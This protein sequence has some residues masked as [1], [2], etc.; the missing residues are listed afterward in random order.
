MIR[1]LLLAIACATVASAQEIAMQPFVI[2]HVNRSNSP[3]DVSFLLDAPA[4]RDGFVRIKDGHLIKPNGERLRLWGVNLTG[5][6]RGPHNLP[7]K[8]M[9][10]QWPD[11]LARFGITCVR[12]HFLDHTTRERP[13]GLIESS[14]DDTSRLDAERLDRLDFFIAE[15]KQRGIYSDLN[16]NVGRNYKPGDHVPDSQLFG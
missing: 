2:D 13:Q 7:P 4:G 9:A 10:P 16:L 5:F 3:A 14:R 6:T 1:T 8:E 11:E 12:F 15:L